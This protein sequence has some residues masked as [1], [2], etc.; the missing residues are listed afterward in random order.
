LEQDIPVG[1][2]QVIVVD[3]GSTDRTP[4]IVRQF[5]PRVRLIRKPNGGQASAFNVGIP[6]AAGDIVAFLDGDDW[7]A[8]GKVKAVLEAF[9]KNPGIAAVGH[10]YFEVHGDS[11]P[12]DML[13]PQKTRL[14]DLSSPEAARIANLGSMLLG[15]SRLAIRRAVLERVL[16]IP[17]QL[18]FA[19]DTPIFVPAL[20]LGGALI[21]D[22]PL[23][24]Y[25]LH[26][27][28]ASRPGASLR[29]AHHNYVRIR[30]YE[31]NLFLVDF[32]SRRL[33]EL[34][35]KPQIISAFLEADKLKLDRFQLQR[36]GGG[37]LKVL[38]TEMRALRSEYRNTTAG[39]R[40]FKGL[41]GALALALPP[42]RFYDLRDW[43]SHRT[44]MHR[45]RGIFGQAEPVVPQSLFQ[46]RPVTPGEK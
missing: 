43:Y 9:E 40:L 17:N 5:E 1:D 37:R 28:E 29:E 2:M 27:P 23:C 25:R 15:T 38:S 33:Q 20:A 6:E 18:I 10:G 24:Y 11:P 46:R 26:S 4:D 21:L 41:I 44:G 7:W 12:A 30:D 42:Q 8:Q 35:V 19:A 36:D 13:V 32:L 22:Q 31:L 34:G 14:L 39:Y 3:D 16:P 45:L